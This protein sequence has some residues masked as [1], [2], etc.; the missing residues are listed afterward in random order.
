MKDLCYAAT[1][2][3]TEVFYSCRSRWNVSFVGVYV[4]EICYDIHQNSIFRVEVVLTRKY[5]PQ[6]GLAQRH[7]QLCHIKSKIQCRHQ[8]INIPRRRHFTA[9]Y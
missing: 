8:S 9:S 6:F 7:I 4:A 3:M 5:T 2:C 1:D